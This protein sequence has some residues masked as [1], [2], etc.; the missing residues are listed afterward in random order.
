VRYCTVPTKGK[1]IMTFRQV[2][3]YAPVILVACAGA[4]FAE[5]PA[6]VATDVA[7]AKTDMLAAIGIVISAMVAVWGLIKLAKKL[8]WN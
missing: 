5:L 1:I 2:K 6:S 4:A 8:G 3:K 7:S